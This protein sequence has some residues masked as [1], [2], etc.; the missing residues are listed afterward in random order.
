MIRVR[1]WGEV[2]DFL[3]G[4]SMGMYVPYTVHAFLVGDTLID[5][6]AFH[7]RR[8]FMQALAGR[9]VGMIVNTHCHEDH[10]GNNAPIR[11][12][13]GAT[14]YAREE[15]LP[16]ISDPVRLGLRLYQRVVWGCPD[17]S[18]AAPLGVSIELPER[19]FRVIHTP[20]HSPDHVCLLEPREGWLF[21]GD[22]FCGRTVRYLRRDENFRLILS[23]LKRLTA[24]DFSSIFCGLKGRIEY[25]REALGAKIGFME[26]LQ[27]R[28]M[29]LHRKGYPPREIRLRILGREGAMHYLSAAHFSKQHV[30]DSILSQE[31][32]SPGGMLT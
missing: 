26:E 23:S 28:V 13:F 7:A 16:F 8:E 11:Q 30:V 1:A 24:F 4:R 12:V 29:D 3:M 9:R 6:G 25:G 5:T 14:A 22:L 17:P 2:T 18:R 21:T 27:A 20:G 32:I 15:A 31:E 19:V 10:I